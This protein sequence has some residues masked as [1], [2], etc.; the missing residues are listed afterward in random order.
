[1]AA[2][3]KENSTPALTNVF[4][5]LLEARKR[6]L[7]AGV[8]K[9]GLNRH[10]EIKYFELEDIVPVITPIAHELGLLFLTTFDNEYARM[11]V[12]DVEH[13]ENTIEF[14]S[15][16]RE[17]E[18]IE[19]TRTGGKLTNAIQ[20]LGSAETYQRRY[21]YMTALDVVENDTFDSELG[22]PEAA[23]TTKKLASAKKAPVTAEQRK[24]IKQE[25]VDSNGQADDLQ[26][27]ALK[28][29][30]EKL[31]ELDPDQES[32][33]QDIV[34]QTDKLTNI[35]KVACEQLITELAQLV[36]SYDTVSTSTE[37]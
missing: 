30:L 36:E 22:A 3:N 32:F 2:S 35:S 28:A 6:F 1:M 7:E 21:L 34:V 4:A 27:Q 16:M 37:A 20:N 33:I 15:P 17:I 29:L 8:K 31:L 19:S 11:K 25:V 14:T 24:E 5:K 12:V 18:S 10:L 13:P 23:A 9:T 26:I